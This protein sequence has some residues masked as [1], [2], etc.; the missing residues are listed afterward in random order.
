MAPANEKNSALATLFD[1]EQALQYL[2]MVMGDLGGMKIN[3]R[4]FMGPKKYS[5]FCPS[6]EHVVGAIKAHGPL[7]FNYYVGVCPRRSEAKDGG[8]EGVAELRY[9]WADLDG[10]DFGGGKDEALSRLRDF[11]LRP[12]FTI[13]SGNGYHGYWQLST[14]ILIQGLGSI[15]EAERY[16]KGLSAELGADMS[17]AEVARIMRLPGTYNLKDPANPKLVHFVELS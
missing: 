17:C 12:T 13:D 16:L 15:E 4:R 9:L 6:V 2:N 7:K 8:K 10:K 11:S 5:T 3:L 1:L 14:P